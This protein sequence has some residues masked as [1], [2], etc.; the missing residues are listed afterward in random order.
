MIGIDFS[1]SQSKIGQGEDLV[2][3]SQKLVL[4]LDVLVIGCLVVFASTRP[5]LTGVPCL[6]QLCRFI[7]AAAFSSSGLKKKKKI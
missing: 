4:A 5:T 2:W 3:F 6:M 1:S 7:F